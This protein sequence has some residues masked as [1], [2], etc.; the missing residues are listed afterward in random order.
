MKHD[1]MRV[2][3]NEIKKP[4][5]GYS[6]KMKKLAANLSSASK[7]PDNSERVL[8]LQKEHDGY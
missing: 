5:G 6:E 3:Q 8:E 7:R 2:I 4:M 1:I